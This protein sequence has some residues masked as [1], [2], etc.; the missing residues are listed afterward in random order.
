MNEELIAHIK[1]LLGPRENLPG[2]LG[3]SGRVL[4]SSWDTVRKARY[5]VM[6]LNP[7]GEAEEAEQRSDTIGETLDQHPKAWNYFSSDE[8][9][10]HAGSVLSV[11]AALGAEPNRRS[12][13]TPC[14]CAARPRGRF[15][16]TAGRSGMITVRPCM[17]TFS[18]SSSPTSWCA[19]GS[20]AGT[21]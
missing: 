21:T 4:M 15:P 18:G 13:R 7:G 12:P 1:G 11:M 16:P 10:G 9:A 19:S 6:G 14:S 17:R 20:T 2:I 5:Y 8:A 3:R